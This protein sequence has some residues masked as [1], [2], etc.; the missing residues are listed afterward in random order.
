MP[1]E[2]NAYPKIL[3]SVLPRMRNRVAHPEHQAIV[4]P[5]EALSSIRF[6]AE[7]VN[8]LYPTT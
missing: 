4:F 8:Q 2:I 7:F 5:Q 3:A 1:V 6:A